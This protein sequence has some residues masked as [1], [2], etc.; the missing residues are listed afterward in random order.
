MS[1]FENTRKPVGLGGKIMY[2]IM[3]MPVCYTQLKLQTNST[4]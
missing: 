2:A 3:N 1:F 4:V